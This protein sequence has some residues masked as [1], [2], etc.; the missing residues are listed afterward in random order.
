L[1][2]I[3]C[4]FE[5]AGD[6][7]SKEE[8][9]RLRRQQLAAWRL[10]KEQ[11]KQDAINSDAVDLNNGNSSNENGTGGKHDE[12][13][14][15]DTKAL[16]QQRIAEWKRKRELEKTPKQTESPLEVKNVIKTTGLKLKTNKVSGIVLKLP[17]KRNVI[18]EN[19]SD[20]EEPARPKFKKPSFNMSKPVTKSDQN[21]EDELDLY[22]SNLTKSNVDSGRE[23]IE[24]SDEDEVDDESE[25]DQ[26]SKQKLLSAKFKKL[27]NEKELQ[28]ID[29]SSIA[30]LSFRKDFY[31][32]PLELQKLSQDE[33]D[34]IRFEMDDI[35]VQGK[36]CPKPILKWNHLGLPSTFMKVIEED[37]HYTSPSSIQAQALPAIM[38]GH[39]VIGIAKTGSGKTIS[40]I[41]PMLRHV[42]DQQKVKQGEGPIALIMTPTRELALQIHKEVS[43]FLKSLTDIRAVCCYGGSNIEP[44]IAE[45]KK[46]AEIII[47]T[48]GRIIDLLAAN[49]GRVTNLNRTTYLVLDEADR[50][51]DMGFEPQVTKVLSQVRPNRQTIL[52]S[53]TFPKKMEF[54]AKKFLNLPIEI[55]VGGI[56]V[57]A[58]EIEQKVEVFST[59]TE[60]LENNKFERLVTIIEEYTLQDSKSKIL[61]FVE[62]QLLAD[63][64][65]VKL[66]GKNIPS[67]AI[68]GGK[69]QLDR[70]YA[71]R[72][73]SSLSSGIN[74]LIATSIAARGLDVK[75]LKLVINYDAANHM[76]DYVHRVGRTGRAGNKG[77]AITFIASNQGRAANDLVKAMKMSNVPEQNFPK[78]LMKIYHK[79]IERAKAGEEKAS[80]GFGGKGLE[81]LDE[82][83]DSTKSMQRRIFGDNDDTSKEP[84]PGTNP[85]SDIEQL[86]PDFK[87]IEGRA[88]ETSGPDRCKFHS[89]ITI[90]DLPQTARWAIVNRE[91]L[92]KII[93]TT[94][95]SI[96]NKGQYY[97]PNTKVKED[98]PKLYLLVEGLTEASVNDANNLIRD[99]MIAGLELA[100]K[101]G[102]MAP[103]TKY[104]V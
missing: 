58:P 69:D 19:D 3:D 59:K 37:L 100:A 104:T 68:H 27:Q 85:N 99:R 41:L 83:R 88:P 10:K 23:I 49:G 14:A 52:F 78:E 91:S 5:C 34:L 28:T 76:E 47:G 63:D 74:V 86:L 26:D 60:D 44:Q 73:F 62:K 36:G 55:T 7:I 103:M 20:E 35:T 102:K 93:E 53:A 96:T 15:T 17:S 4:E 9:L 46:G 81:K 43:T 70:K 64:L 90:N 92:S 77:T 32:E 48:P 75:G 94:G 2:K 24:F 67:L 71:I 82:I 50:M 39:D 80:F 54:L 25:D 21:D 66:L 57:V 11:E 72:D 79:F 89:R 6:A 87:I 8:K 31:K 42:G 97:G 18:F 65:L 38:S 101:E 45:L 51:L 12:P 98:P 33:V 16:R 95:T 29:H 61:V 22:I 56:S 40:F 30:Y 84:T 1:K 13:V